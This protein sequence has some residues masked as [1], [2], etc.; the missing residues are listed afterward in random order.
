MPRREDQ[1]TVIVPTRNR[2]SVVVATLKLFAAAGVDRQIII[3]DSSDTLDR[4]LEQ[5]AARVGAI[6]RRYP[7]D[8]GLYDKMA[9]AATSAGTPF[10]LA[11][12]DKKLTLPYGIDDLL[13]HL[14]SHGD[15]VSA[16]G[17]VLRHAMQRSD[18]DIYRVH[19]FVP[20]IEDP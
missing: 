15:H 13:S 17:Y 2:A 9:D 5:A 16:S 20:S 7:S 19:I 14:Q 4:S 6:V 8:I 3:A 10:V 1:L 11:V 18:V 12:P